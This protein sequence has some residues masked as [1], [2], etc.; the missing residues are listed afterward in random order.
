MAEMKALGSW[1]RSGYSFAEIF[2]FFRNISKWAVCLCCLAMSNWWVTPHDAMGTVTFHLMHSEFI[3]VFKEVFLDKI[4]NL[5]SYLLLIDFESCKH[6][7]LRHVQSISNLDGVHLVC[8]IS[9]QK[10]FPDLRRADRA[11]HLLKLA[12]SSM[13]YLLCV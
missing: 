6:S 10:H 7:I 12:H 11:M 9:F 2:T 5:R 3:S 1:W 8:L 4:V 13:S